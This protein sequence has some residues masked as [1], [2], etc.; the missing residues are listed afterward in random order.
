MSHK[1]YKFI[2]LPRLRKIKLPQF[3]VCKKQD[4]SPQVQ[5]MQEGI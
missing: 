2:N 3:H 5:A 4:F 1:E